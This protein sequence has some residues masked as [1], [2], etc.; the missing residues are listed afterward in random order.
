MPNGSKD[1]VA[2]VAQHARRHRLQ[3]HGLRHAG[4]E[5]AEGLASS[6]ASRAS[7]RRSKTP[8]RQREERYPITRP[9]LIYTAGEPTGAV[10]EYLDWILSA[11][12]QDVVR[13]LGYVPVSDHE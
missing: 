2:L 6:R 11:E 4:R 7:R 13:E 1:V 12:G 8:R 10:K 5:D 9:L 3:R